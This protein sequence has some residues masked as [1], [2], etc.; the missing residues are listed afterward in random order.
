[1]RI[2]I[3]LNRY[4]LITYSSQRIGSMKS[5]IIKTVATNK[6]P[7]DFLKSLRKDSEDIEF[8]I[9]YSERISKKDYRKF[10]EE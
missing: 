1:M 8:A 10:L 4:Y 9:L 2:N 7:V 3:F 6:E 5:Q